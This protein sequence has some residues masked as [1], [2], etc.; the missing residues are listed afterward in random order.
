MSPS[1]ISRKSRISR[2]SWIS[3]KSQKFNFPISLGIFRCLM[4]SPNVPKSK[5]P[6]IPEFPQLPGQYPEIFGYI[7]CC[8][9]LY[10]PVQ[11]WI[12][13]SLRILGFLQARSLMMFSESFL[14]LWL[15]FLTSCFNFRSVRRSHARFK[16]TFLNK[17]RMMPRI[18]IRCNIIDFVWRND[19]RQWPDN[20]QS[21]KVLWLFIVLYDCLNQFYLQL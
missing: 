2:I 9:G 1:P 13:I 16:S 4:V 17:K 5:I 15:F 18:R 7:E 14:I 21:A 19:G 6:K 8:T 10:S 12:S 20:V 11:C 3:R